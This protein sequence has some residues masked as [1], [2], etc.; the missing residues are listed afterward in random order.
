MAAVSGR[1]GSGVSG[2]GGRSGFSSMEFAACADMKIVPFEILLIDDDPALHEIIRA[3][4]DL[5]D[6][7]F[8]DAFNGGEGLEQA[9]AGRRDLIVLDV[10]MPGMDGFEVLRR[11]KADEGLRTIPVVMLT[12]AG[13]IQDKVRAFELGAIDFVTKPFVPAELRARISSVLRTKT[14]QDQ[15]IESNRALTMARQAAESATRAK[16]Q[17]LATMS[18]ELRTPMNG[19]IA[20]T[21]LLMDSGL[22]REQ[23]E[24]VETIR[25]GGETLLEQINQ[26]LDFSKIE[27]GRMELE[28]A[29]MQLR[30][31][32]ERA[33]DLLAPKAAEKGLNLACELADDV[34]A[35]VLGDFTRVRQV[36]LNLIGNAI[37]FTARG[38]VVVTARVGR[39]GAGDLRE[40]QFTVRDTGIGI[41][42]EAQGKLFESFSQVD[43]STTRKYGG[44]GLG[45]AIC[46]SLVEMMGGRI[47][48]ESREG[49]GTA[50]HFV[51]PLTATKLGEAPPPHVAS[52]ALAGRRLLIVSDNATNRRLIAACA[53]R[54]G[55]RVVE[56]GGLGDALTAVTAPESPDLAILDGEMPDMADARLLHLIR[57]FPAGQSLPL[58]ALVYPGRKLA[59]PEAVRWWVGTVNKPV[60]ETQLSAAL[61]EGLAGG[62]S[63]GAPR[64]ARV[65]GLDRE[66]A[67]KVPLRVLLVDDNALNQ[68]VGARVLRQLGYEARLAGGGSEAIELLAREP[69]DVVFMD[70][71]MPVLDGLEATRRIRHG[72]GPLSPVIIAVTA[73]ALPGDREKCLAAGMNDYLS[74]PIRAEAVEELL[75]YW[76]PLAKGAGKVGAVPPESGG[77]VPERKVERTATEEGAVVDLARLE[78]LTGGDE[79]QIQELLDLY[80]EQTPMTLEKLKAAVAAGNAGE[81]QRLAHNSVG[82]SASCGIVR[83]VPVMRLIEN[84]GQTG[85]L[86]EAE[87]MLKQASAEF[88]RVQEFIR[89]RVSA[90]GVG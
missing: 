62:K 79:R 1:S 24:L 31:C 67:A 40:V 9:A 55:M 88:G 72:A 71:Q 3:S 53:V 26:I 41:A 87:A 5:P 4:L 51:L 47:W 27:S 77:V 68:K 56:A 57:A 7:R 18:H 37:K 54:W 59:A 70:V 28:R 19:V 84:C 63:P 23:R 30:Q 42:Q 69:F 22:T 17:F 74:K 25:E 44:T 6:V 45:L 21:G 15:L 8:V 35:W 2:C 43:A 76:G 46:K 65:S 52:P 11:L 60:K 90:Q 32:V 81:I 85:R 16:S 75:R 50:M 86:E 13:N 64:E 20:M 58:L 38:D 83:M 39:Q 89:A 34:P 12:G 80:L 14:L 82:A 49:E 48:M 61:L 10:G 36:L 78:N 66:L 29:P 73:N 33:M